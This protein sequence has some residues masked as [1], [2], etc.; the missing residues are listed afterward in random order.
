MKKNDCLVVNHLP[1]VE[2]GN[3]ICYSG[4][5][6][7]QSP[8]DGVYPTYRQVHEDLKI[9]SRNWQYLRMYDSSPH[10]ETVL[11]V[12][13]QEKM[14]FKVMLGAE[15][16]PELNNPLC[17]WLDV[18]P[19]EVLARNARENDSEIEGLVELARGYPD[20]VFAVSAGNEATVEWS[21]HL[22]PV[23]RVMGFARRL[24][25]TIS[26]PVTFCE[27][28]VPWT[29]KLG[30]LVEILDFI[31]VHSYPVWEYQGIENALDYTQQNYASV[32]SHYPD[33]PV[34]LT[35]AGWTTRANGQGIDPDNASAEL[36]ARFIPQ[37]MQWSRKNGILTFLFEAFDEPWKGSPHPDEP[38]KH[39]GLF[40]VD[41]KPKLVMRAQ[42]LGI[43]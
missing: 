34:I 24:K 42:Y 13:R 23:E 4:Y 2:Y 43:F 28:Y 31:S 33:K 25:E 22:V 32:A 17:P 38:E 20:N 15:L 8:R 39:W 16:K 12:I 21:D 40:T 36:Q 5:R 10:A 19:P 30:P 7:G 18:I 26:Q 27:N 29:E 14:D 9:L 41:R 35:E 37:L 3:A 6:Q 1:G 11:N